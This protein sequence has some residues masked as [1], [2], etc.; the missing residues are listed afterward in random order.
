[1]QRTRPYFRGNRNRTSRNEKITEYVLK[2]ELTSTEIDGLNG[3]V[4][5]LKNEVHFLERQ[6]HTIVH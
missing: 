4:N 3:Q 2:H 1:V 5:E 6:L